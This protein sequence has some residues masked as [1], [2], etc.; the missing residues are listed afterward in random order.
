MNL[1][2][3][4]R[5]AV[6][7]ATS[8]DFFLFCIFEVQTRI[9]FFV[10]SV[11]GESI[12]WSTLNIEFWVVSISFTSLLQYISYAYN[13]VERKGSRNR[14]ILFELQMTVLH[15]HTHTPTE[16]LQERQKKGEERKRQKHMMTWIS[17]RL[18]VIKMKSSRR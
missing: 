2:V 15:T 8:F 16:P 5:E 4:S 18:I 9:H 10:Y 13:K 11:D 12:W 7:R 6:R 14:V 17:I 1:V 3:T